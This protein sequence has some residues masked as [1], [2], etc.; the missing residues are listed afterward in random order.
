MPAWFQ[1][2]FVL[3][4]LLVN[5]TLINNSEYK[6]VSLSICFFE[7][8]VISK[9]VYLELLLSVYLL[10]LFGVILTERENMDTIRL[11]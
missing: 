8:Y 7:S 9:S 2:D 1:L 10:L 6:K 3:F 11:I 5:M 4:S